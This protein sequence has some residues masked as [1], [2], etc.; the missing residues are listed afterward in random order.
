MKTI[1]LLIINFYQNWIS[2]LSAPCCRFYPTCSTYTA[3]AIETYGPIKGWI[4]GLKRI[5][6]CH[7]LCQGGIDFVP[8]ERKKT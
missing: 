4:F 5:L 8:Q 2:P 6:R 3:S 1:S 7:P